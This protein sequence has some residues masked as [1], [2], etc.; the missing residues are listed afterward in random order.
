M[1]LGRARSNSLAALQRRYGDAFGSSRT[2]GKPP[3]AV[4]LQYKPK[5]QRGELR[6]INCSD[7]RT[8]ICR[9]CHVALLEDGW[10][11]VDARVTSDSFITTATTAPERN[12]SAAIDV[13]AHG[14]PKLSAMRPAESAP[15][16]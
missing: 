12:V 8:S 1:G 15:I 16:A 9:R 4:K 14:S 6:R 5:R 10:D 3:V 2:A 7:K 11:S 13:I